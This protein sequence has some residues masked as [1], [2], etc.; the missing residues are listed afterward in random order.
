[1]TIGF[2]SGGSELSTVVEG[3]Q[4]TAQGL[5]KIGSATLDAKGN[6]TPGAAVGGATWLATGSPVGLIVS[7]GMKL[8]GEAS[9]SATV[10]GRAKQTAKEIA[11]RMKLRFQEEGWISQ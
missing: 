4:V 10:E 9:G 6:K 2:G 5:R 3:Y 7:G 1:L 8:Y 11:E